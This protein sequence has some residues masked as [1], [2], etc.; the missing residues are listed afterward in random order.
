MNSRIGESTVSEGA[1]NFNNASFPKGQVCDWNE[2]E[3]G[4]LLPDNQSVR[5]RVVVSLGYWTVDNDP[6]YNGIQ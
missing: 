6:Q 3:C 2:V 4:N 1:T 5:K